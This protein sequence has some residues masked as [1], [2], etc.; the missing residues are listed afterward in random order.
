MEFVQAGPH[1]SV[2]IRLPIA[3]VSD[4]DPVCLNRPQGRN[5]AAVEA[6]VP[7]AADWICRRHA[8]HEQAKQKAA[9][10]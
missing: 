10:R 2:M 5:H 4:I 7:A 1:M 3:L 6:A 8:C 9:T